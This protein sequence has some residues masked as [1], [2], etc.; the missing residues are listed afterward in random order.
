[1]TSYPGVDPERARRYRASG[2]WDGRLLDSYLDAAPPERT[3]V[4]DGAHRL[5]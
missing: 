3:A 2:A 5:T 1:M 4:V